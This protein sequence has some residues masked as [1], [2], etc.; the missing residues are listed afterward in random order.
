MRSGLLLIL[1]LNGLL[2]QGQF[3][4]IQHGFLLNGMPNATTSGLSW[5]DYNR[6]GWDDLTVGQG[7]AEILLFRNIQGTLQLVY[8]FPNTTQVKSFQWVDY[9]N[10]GDA[11][12]F[13]CAVNASCRLWRNNGGLNFTD[14]SANLNIPAP[15]E[16]SMGAAWAD[17]DRDGW[18]DVYVCNYFGLNWLLRNN[19][20]GTFQNVAATLGV[21][22][23]VRPT[24]MCSWVD[25]DNDCLLD[26]YVANDL[27]QPNEMYRNTGSGFVAVGVETGLAYA[28]ESMGIS[29]TDYDNDLDLDVYITN[30]ADGNK[31]LR[32]DDGIFTDVAVSAGVAVNALSWGCL[33]MDFDHDGRDD[34]HVGTQAPLV[35]QNV[36]FLFRQQSDTTFTNISLPTDIGNCFASAKGDLNN[37]GFWD[38]ADS[39]VLPTSF[40]VWRNNGV[41]G[42]WVKLSLRGAN[43]NTDAIGTKL[44]FTHGGQTHYTHTFCGESFFGQ[45]SQYEILS[46]GTSTALDSLRVEWPSGRIEHYFNIPVNSVYALVEG[47]GESA[48]ISVSKDF[49]C[50]G[51]DEVALIAPDGV[52]FEWSTGEPSQTISI[53][54][55]G[56]YSVLYANTCGFEDSLFVSIEQLPQPVLAENVQHP[57]C[58]G[59]SDG[60]VGLLI[61]GAQP[62]SLTWTFQQQPVAEC[63]LPGGL[64]EFE[65][66]DALGCTYDGTVSLTE[67]QPLVLTV[68]SAVVCTD[69]SASAQWEATGG[70]A[71]YDF[72]VLGGG[73][74][75]NLL[76]GEYTAIVTDANGCETQDV[77]TIG[78]FPEVNFIANVD[79]I[80]EGSVA[81]LEYIG[82]G[83]VLP[84]AYDWQG[85]NPSALSAGE[86]TFTLTDGN[87]CTDAVQLEVAIFPPLEIAISDLTNASG[88]DNGSVSLTISGGNEPYSVL[89]NTGSTETVLENIGSGIYTVT[90]TDANGCQ[91]SA[92]QNI[93]D[94][95]VDELL[96]LVQFYPNPFDDIIQIRTGKS[97]RYRMYNAQGGCVSAGIL[98]GG[99]N[100]VQLP[101]LLSGI[102]ILRITND[103][104]DG[105]YKLVKR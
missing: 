21:A 23:S 63:M 79:S 75:Q 68:Q 58:Y 57:S 43:G 104:G 92:A 93:I 82:F 46:L 95:G 26:L 27:N 48:S 22:N 80:C 83:G 105:S 74:E 10:D 64:Y 15:T 36:N 56:E 20:D 40:K 28:I 33:W 94:L 69:A 35:A 100:Q 101:S 24:Y 25:Y 50:S 65:A 5:Y 38:F 73:N 49:L 39:F 103:S 89:W 41:G 29:W 7:N 62:M 4:E 76:P 60:C 72:S 51:Q 30:A 97:C 85:Q 61:D 81:V 98:Q 31:L 32:N 55:P 9:D 47:S 84:Y 14:V 18:L 86:Y 37:D 8:A 12:L 52:S 102:Y 71:P 99:L 6:D 3:T 42:N 45:D 34:L 78:A 54:N 88:G 53:N 13:V 19:G 67:P 59:S 70:T 17:Y 96:G 1:I 44:Y 2:L 90:V 11:D 16:D 66:I 91:Q 87:G 77:F